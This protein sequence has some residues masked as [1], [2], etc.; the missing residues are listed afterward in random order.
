VKFW[1]SAI[2][3]GFGVFSFA[4]CSRAG[5]C[6]VILL[7]VLM[8]SILT[9]NADPF[10]CG[11]CLLIM[12]LG[13]WLK[14]LLPLFCSAYDFGLVWFGSECSLHMLDRILYQICNLKYHLQPGTVAHFCNPSYSG[15][16]DQEDR[17]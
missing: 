1:L 8:T 2:S 9:N 14:N 17:S 15:S 5:G 4:D 3:P 13:G 11:F 7:M 16:R 6:A 12:D 10:F